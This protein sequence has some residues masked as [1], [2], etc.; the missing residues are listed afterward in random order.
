MN[1][2]ASLSFLALRYSRAAAQFSAARQPKNAAAARLMAS[3]IR[4]VLA[5][6]RSKS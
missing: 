4:A 3:R 6:V 5:M 2:T 1:P